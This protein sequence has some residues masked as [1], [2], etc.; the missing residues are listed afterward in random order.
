MSEFGIWVR[1]YRVPVE[2]WNRV[3]FFGSRRLTITGTGLKFE[4]FEMGFRVGFYGGFGEC[5]DWK[6]R[7]MDEES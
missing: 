1:Y 5:E 2:E 3:T 4:S 7:E 6:V